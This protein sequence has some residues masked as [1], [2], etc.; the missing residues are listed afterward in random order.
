MNVVLSRESEVVVVALIDPIPST[1]IVYEPE[2]M[3]IGEL[4]N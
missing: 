4:V 2:A 3:T 1:F